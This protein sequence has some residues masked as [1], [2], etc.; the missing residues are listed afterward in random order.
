MASVLEALP[1]L[2][3]AELELLAALEAQ[4]DNRVTLMRGIEAARIALAAAALDHGNRTEANV[5]AAELVTAHNE[6]VAAQAALD[7]E[8]DVNK[9]PALEQAVKDWAD[10]I[11]ALTAAMPKAD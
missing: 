2:S 3:L 9:H 1:A 6:L 5:N 4:G 11:D 8:G 7:A 10:R